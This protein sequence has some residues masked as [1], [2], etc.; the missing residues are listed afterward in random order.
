MV[1]LYLIIL[2]NTPTKLK[3][4]AIIHQVFGC[5]RPGKLI[6]C[7]NT[8]KEIEGYDYYYQAWD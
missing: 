8:P 6:M 7:V 2:F 3:A 4:I 1:T 5:N